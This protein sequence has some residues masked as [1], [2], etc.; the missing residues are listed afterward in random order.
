MASEI[1]EIVQFLRLTPPFHTL[2]DDQVA[3]LSRRIEVSYARAQDAVTTAGEHNEKLFIVRSGSVELRLAGD[4]LTARLGAGSCFAYPSLLRG[5]EVRNTTVAIED[6]L[7]YAIPADDFHRLR[8]ADETFRA[9]FDDDETSRIRHALEQNR[10][11]RARELDVTALDQLVRRGEPVACRPDSSIRDAVRLMHDRNVSTLAICNGGDL[12]GIFTDK[13]LRNRVVA[14]EFALDRPVSEVM[15]DHPRTLP[16]HASIAQAMAM[17]A[18][19]AFRHIPLTGQA[20][21]LVAIL[22]A[23]DILAFLGSNA[24]DIGLAIGK[25]QDPAALVA[26]TS[27]IPDAFAKMVANGF[28]A[29]HAMRFTSALGEA[30]HR[31]AAELAEKELGPPPVPYALVVFGSLAREEQLVGSDQDNGLVIHDSVDAAGRAYFE[32]LG[33]RISDLLDAAGFVYCKGGIMAKNAE[34]RL[35]LSEWRARYEHWITNPSED[36][37]LRATIF[38]DMRCVHGPDSLVRDLHRDVVARAAENPIFVSFLA[39]DALRSKIPL[40]IF[41]NLVLEKSADGHRVFNAKAQAIMPIIDIA[42]TQALAHGIEAVGTLERLASLA[43]AGKMASED[44]QSLEDAFLFANDLRIAH[45]SDQIRAGSEP[46]NAI[47]PEKLSP[48]EREYLK[49]AFAVIR[50]ALDSLRRNF[51]GGIA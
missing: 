43:K 41:R 46:D 15:T 3:M 34:Q 22:S 12:V 18:S 45:Q 39:R 17:M 20:G 36:G 50:R 6:T 2:P 1:G 26:A 19:G 4:D 13:D 11:E 47:E 48:L 28:D 33:G 40:G 21:E 31:R 30:A 35:S 25:A 14:A 10:S 44:A 8:T 42:R 9:F 49:D 24:I 37:I 16:S 29:R 27:Q 7:L 32:T 23:S 38:F 51:A 5:G